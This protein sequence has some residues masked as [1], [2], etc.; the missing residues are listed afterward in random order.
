MRNELQ[1]VA[2]KRCGS[3]RSLP[4]RAAHCARRIPQSLARKYCDAK[5]VA[6]QVL[7]REYSRWDLASGA[8]PRARP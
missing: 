6:H 5:E 1:V 2:I 8:F 4:F 3:V 7:S